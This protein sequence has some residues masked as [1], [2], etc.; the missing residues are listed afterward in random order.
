[1]TNGDGLRESTASWLEVL[2]ELKAR[3]LDAA[4]LLAVGDGALGFWAALGEI[5]PE[6]RP[7]RCFGCTRRPTSSM[8]C[9][10]ARRARPRPGCTRS[11]WR[12]TRAAAISA[13]DAFL[14]TTARS[15]RRPPEALIWP[16][17]NGH[18]EVCYF[19]LVEDV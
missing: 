9:P 12:P 10:R 11:G 1:M 8:R 18:H 16:P 5:Y 14:K 3:G 17:K 2:R 13:F 6:T 4:P 19:D 15:I 7:Q